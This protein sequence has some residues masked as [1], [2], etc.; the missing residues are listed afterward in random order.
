MVEGK[1]A[2]IEDCRDDPIEPVH[3][4]GRR[5]AQRLDALRRK[6]R[7]AKPVALGAVAHVVRRAIDLDRELCSRAIE[8]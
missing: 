5:N 7:I 2:A 6:R 1:C 4:I 3:H 8:I